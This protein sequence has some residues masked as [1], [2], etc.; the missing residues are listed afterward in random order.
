MLGVLASLGCADSGATKRP[1][2]YSDTARANYEKGLRELKDENFPEAIKYLNFVKNKFPFSRYATL[3]ELR[4]ADALYAQEKYPQ[5]IDAYKLF[6]KFHPTHPQVLDGYAS[7]RIA[8]GNVKQIPGDWWLLPPSYEKDQSATRDALREL[9]IFLKT[10]EQS[11]YRKKVLELHRVCLRKL[12]AHELYVA[13]FYLERDKPKATILR[14]ERVLQRFPGA[15]VHPEVM[16]LLGKTY[17]KLNK[18]KKAEQ[19][20]AS[21]IKKYPRDHHAAKAK[22]FLEYLSSRRN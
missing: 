9:T 6:I 17:L 16:L 3:A 22:L 14:L 1:V 13:R 2:S 18:R 10:Y 11:K 7:Y 12:A 8:E 19:T 5:A 4:M 15:G 21:L 20:F